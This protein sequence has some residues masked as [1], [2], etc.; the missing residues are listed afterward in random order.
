MI[1]QTKLT[2]SK[3]YFICLHIALVGL[4]LILGSIYEAKIAFT[5]SK[6]RQFVRSIGCTTHMPLIY[7][8]HICEV[9][10]LNKD[11]TNEI[12]IRLDEQ[13][14]LTSELIVKGK[15]LFEST[16]ANFFK[17]GETENFIKLSLIRKTQKLGKSFQMMLQ[18]IRCHF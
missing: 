7:K 18:T 3:V 15:P 17:R 8:E 9:I 12:S 5:I 16:A 11:V 1:I 10:K 4:L 14:K 13:N 2:H 6:G